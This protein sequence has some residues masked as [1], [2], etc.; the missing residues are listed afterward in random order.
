MK[1]EIQECGLE[2]KVANDGVLDVD[3]MVHNR[4]LATDK[5]GRSSFD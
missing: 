3:K 4:S 2:F 5:M 1:E